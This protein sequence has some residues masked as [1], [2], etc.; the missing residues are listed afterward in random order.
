M[1]AS[2]KALRDALHKV[3]KARM[4][5]KRIYSPEAIYQHGVGIE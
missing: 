4:P 2:Q 5:K 1:R 3:P